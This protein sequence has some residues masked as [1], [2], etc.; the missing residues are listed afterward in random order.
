LIGD[1]KKSSGDFYTFGGI[2]GAE[3]RFEFNDLLNNARLRTVI[4]RVQ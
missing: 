3:S 1:L 2:L 4:V